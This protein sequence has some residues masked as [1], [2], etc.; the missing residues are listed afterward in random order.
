MQYILI[1]R[2][3]SF[4]LYLV[5]LMI[6]LAVPVSGGIDISKAA[7]EQCNLPDRQKVSPDP[8]VY[9]DFYS[10][11]SSQTD[12]GRKRTSETVPGRFAGEKE[13]VAAKESIPSAGKVEKVLVIPIQFS[14]LSFGPSRNKAYFENIMSQLKDYYEKNSGYIPASKGMSISCT[15]TPVVTSSKTMEYYGADST[16]LGSDDAN[17]PIYE[18][19]REAVQLVNP[20]ID[21]SQFDT[22][23]NHI[24]DHLIIIHAGN[25]QESAPSTNN[26]WSHS[27]RIRNGEMVDGVAAYNY[28][29][30]PET[31][32]LGVFAHEFG[33]DIGLPDLY[34]SDKNDNGYTYGAGDWDVMGTGSW[35]HRPGEAAGTSPANLSAWSKEFLGWSAVTN[36]AQDGTYSLTNAS[37]NNTAYRFWTNGNTSGDEYYL[38]EYRRK[39][40]Y[41]AGL[42]GEG[43]LIWHVDKQWFNT[44]LM[45]G[46]TTGS[47]FDFNAINAFKSR[48]G[49]E[50]EQADGKRD[51]WNLVNEGDEGDPF[52]GITNNSTFG[53]VPYKMNYSN[54]D[55]NRYSYTEVR[56]IRV[57]GNTATAD[58]YIQKRAPSVVPVINSP[59]DNSLA[60]TQPVFTWT[61]SVQSESYKL[62]ISESNNFSTSLKEIVLQG[63]TSSLLYVDGY[64]K[65]TLPSD[66]K[67]DYGKTYY[68]RIGAVN[69]EGQIWSDIKIINGG[70]WIQKASLAHPRNNLSS[71]AV[72]GKII[73]L[74][75]QTDRPI[76][77]VDAYDPVSDIW[78]EIS[79][80]P[81]SSYHMYSSAA[82]TAAGCIYLMGGWDGDTDVKDNIEFNPSTGIWTEKADMTT[83]RD[84]H[85]AIGAGGRIYVF[86]GRNQIRQPDNSVIE[87]LLK[88][89]EVYD[90]ATDRW[91]SKRD[92]PYASAFFGICEAGGKIYVLGGMQQDGQNIILSDKVQVYDPVNNTWEVKAHMPEAQW[93]TEAVSV[94][95][96]VITVGSTNNTG[97]LSYIIRK[98]DPSAD[99][100]SDLG[101]MPYPFGYPDLVA[102]NNSIYLFGQSSSEDRLYRLD[103]VETIMAF[104]KPAPPTGITF[105][106]DGANAL[107]LM[108]VTQSME[109]SLD[110][111]VAYISVTAEDQAL[112]LGQ[113]S[114]LDADKDIR[115]RYKAAAQTPASAALL[116]NLLSGPAAP[117]VT[118]DDTANVINGI[119]NTMEY[120]M[121]QINWTKYNNNPPD[122]SGNKTVYVRMPGT[123][124]TMPSAAVA[125]NFTANPA[126]NPGGD[127]GGGGGAPPPPPPP[128]PP[129][130]IVPPPVVPV[131]IPTSSGI[132]IPTFGNEELG[133]QIN[134]ANSTVTAKI[135]NSAIHA[136]SLDVS[137]FGE[138]TRKGK[139]L[140]IDSPKV[141]ITLPAGAVSPDLL[142]A[143]GSDARLQIGMEPVAAVDAAQKLKDAAKDDGK[144][145]FAIGGCIF[146][147]S[148]QI[149]TPDKTQVITSFSV[150]ITVTLSLSDVNLGSIDPDILGVYY[151]NETTG[152]WEYMG[153]TYNAATRSITFTTSHFSLYSVMKNEVTFDDIK[154]HWAKADIEKLASRQITAGIG[155]NKFNPEGTVTRSEFISWL[156]RA[157]RL[158]KETA[159]SNGMK[160]SQQPLPFKDVAKDKWY[161][162]EVSTAYLYGIA[163]NGV[164]FRPEAKITREEMATMIAAALKLKNKSAG[165]TATQ[166]SEQLKTFKDNGSI[167]DAHR[168]SVAEAVKLGI[169]TGRPGKL[170]APAATATRAEGLVMISRLLAK[171]K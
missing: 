135:T 105:S 170:F 154:T 38:A 77:S 142:K 134:S 166:I 169:I 149:V 162:A 47:A 31:G 122:L 48:L 75:G 24:V 130:V 116:I 36:I 33:H 156:V 99:T 55:T 93:E 7:T 100:W 113:A 8:E 45:D 26:I 42:P 119:N 126:V 63:G 141:D 40:G 110:G 3:A 102:L 94:N 139:S 138:I 108:G 84:G 30:E 59:A 96:T 16:G 89:V 132:T 76:L 109:F 67:L 9:P 56:N 147:F 25:G 68:C 66:A 124:V 128:P 165:L 163:G 54:I 21:F 74:G 81:P 112:S 118:A 140:T 92:M 49:V 65:Y 143:A 117:T 131:V 83:A 60:G 22:D 78:T 79:S 168:Q 27:W 23:S 73:V 137:T 53:A 44:V 153:G 167:Q 88:T 71:V 61:S 17:V 20:T 148:S 97:R 127:V 114:G 57:S 161:A 151:Y 80:I 14:N 87:T 155:N 28:T 2:A 64:Y 12:N 106:F 58:Y 152:I 82:T 19:A 157:L 52:P 41:D 90:P 69:G 39:N 5:F 37:I 35:N 85:R 10:T 107:K 50:L 72:N 120:S 123:G 158:D 133:S 43:L 70:E 125:L 103:S 51:L 146:E 145:L 62:Q 6:Q 18:L 129:A 4:L 136:V 115:V 104:V 15:V 32:T 95:G 98:Y 34:D 101:N 86:G 1:K 91:E 111:G 29:C 150:P 164:S 171:L 121:D 46:T 160:S 144:G 13:P 159:Q 11:E